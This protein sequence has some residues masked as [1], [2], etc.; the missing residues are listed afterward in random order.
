MRRLRNTRIASVLALGALV[1]QFALSFAHIHVEGLSRARSEHATLGLAW[2]NARS[3]P[4]QQPADADDD[5]CAICASIY[6]A[7]NSFVPQPPQLVIPLVSETVETREHATG[8][9]TTP[10]RSPF[11]SRAPPLV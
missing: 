2:H 7:A 4:T 9:V 8:V 3:L 5:Y 1:L 6:L 11:Q 10:R